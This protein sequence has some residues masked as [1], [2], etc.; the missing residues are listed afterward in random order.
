MSERGETGRKYVRTTGGARLS[1]LI[2]PNARG[3]LLSCF[4]TRVY[5]VIMVF[6]HQLYFAENSISKRYLAKLIFI[7]VRSNRNIRSETKFK[8]NNVANKYV[9]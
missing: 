1:N 7:R 5:S 6:I 3:V 9:T 8:L 2:D 4:Y